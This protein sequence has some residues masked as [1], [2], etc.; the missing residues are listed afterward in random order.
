MRHLKNGTLLL[1]LLPLSARAQEVED[2]AEQNRLVEGRVLPLIRRLDSDAFEERQKATRLLLRLGPRLDRLGDESLALL[3]KVA[4]ANDDLPLRADLQRLVEGIRTRTQGDEVRRLVGHQNSIVGMAFSPDGAKLA[5]ASWDRTVRVWDVNT[6][7]QFLRLE[8]D[9][10]VQSVA[11]SPD[12]KLIA[13]IGKEVRLWESG[14]GKGRF[15]F[16]DPAWSSGALYDVCFSPDGKRF[17]ACPRDGVLRSW[18]TDTGELVRQWV[19]GR[20]FPLGLSADGTRVY[21]GASEMVACWSLTTGGQLWTNT[22]WVTASGISIYRNLALTPDG[23]QVVTG[24]QDGFLRVFESGSGKVIRTRDLKRFRPLFLALSAAGDRLLIGGG[25]GPLELL[26]FLGEE[27][28]QRWKIP[29][30][31]LS[32][33]SLALSPDGRWASTAGHDEIVRLFQ[34]KGR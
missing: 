15:C 12:G 11:F 16:R 26:T 4:D 6:G 29:E 20:G 7:K 10:Y 21:L 24:N 13:S 31:V 1:L 27:E 9:D 14:T 28:V 25:Q 5:T 23:G 30:G 17:L 33:D 32:V 2:F 3:A 22:T 8:H 34:V 18:D 19:V